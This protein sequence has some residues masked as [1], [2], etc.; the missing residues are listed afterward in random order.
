MKIRQIIEAQE[1]ADLDTLCQELEASESSVRRDLIALESDG[2]LRRVYGGAIATQARD[3]V[4]DF[5][6][7]STRMAEEKKRIAAAAAAL[8][9]DGQTVIFDGGSTT[10]AVA[11]ELVN[12]DLHVITNSLAIADVLHDARRIEVTLTGGYFYP[13]L[14]AM[15]GPICE[16]M[17]AGVSA[18]VVVMGI[19][20]VTEAGFSNSNTLVVGPELKM[21]E[22]SRKVI[23]VADHTKFGRKAVIPLAPL[24]AAH[25][26]VSDSGLDSQYERMI[27]ESGPQVVLA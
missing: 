12:R 17:L 9:E 21:L 23:L 2:V 13:R 20:G 25:V 8:I 11:S 1:F 5:D 7:Q 15:L 14:R 18:D 10:A 26:V 3:H 24:G 19:G 27:R 6:W 4:L 16:Q 22:V